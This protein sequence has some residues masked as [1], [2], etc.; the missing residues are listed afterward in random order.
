M[1]FN[2][3]LLSI[4]YISC[5]INNKHNT[6]IH[7]LLSD[8]N[9]CLSKFFQ[10]RRGLVTSSV[11]YRLINWSF[12]VSCVIACSYLGLAS[13]TG[14]RARFEDLYREVHFGP[15]LSWSTLWLK[16]TQKSHLDKHHHTHPMPFCGNSNKAIAGF[17]DTGYNKLEHFTVV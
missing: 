1:T 8:T 17:Q 13:R 6:S 9:H 3:L 12:G 10:N 11:G 15:T 4:Y 16:L 2:S 7:L 5:Y 14:H